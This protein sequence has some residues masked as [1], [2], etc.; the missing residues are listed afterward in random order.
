MHVES[1]DEAWQDKSV[2]AEPQIHK[3]ES[4]N[5]FYDKY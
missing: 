3:L 1:L 5:Y 4:T 2:V